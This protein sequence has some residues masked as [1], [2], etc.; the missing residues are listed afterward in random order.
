MCTDGSNLDNGTKVNTSKELRQVKKN[1]VNSVNSINWVYLP[2]STL[3]FANG[4]WYGGGL[5]VTPHGNPTDGLLSC[6]NWVTTFWP[7][8]LHVL[9]LYNGKHVEWNH[10][11]TFDGV[12]FI[13]DTVH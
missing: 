12:S 2:S 4:R 9:S 13:V 3:C 6:T 5:Q 1:S 11:S 7:F 10:T 8:I